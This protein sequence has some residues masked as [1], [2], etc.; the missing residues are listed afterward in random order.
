MV[1]IAGIQLG[2]FTDEYGPIFEETA[3]EFGAIYIPKVMKGIFNVQNSGV[4][5]F[6]LTAPV[7]V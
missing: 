3:A 6:T 7:I 5:R 1:A 2:F 4:I